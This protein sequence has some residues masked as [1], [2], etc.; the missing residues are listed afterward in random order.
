MHKTMVL[1]CLTLL[2]AGCSY[3]SVKHLASNPLRL[4]KQEEL[5]MRYWNFLYVN[6]K[7]NHHYLLR[8]IAFP[9][10]ENLPEWGSWIHNLSIAAYLSDELGVVLARDI[11]AH[12]TQRLDPE[13][14]IPV[15]FRLEPK[16]MPESRDVFVTFGY[17]MQLTED[18]CQDPDK[19]HTP[20][21]D[22]RVFFASEGALLR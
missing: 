22:T 11:K 16:R 9:R 17:R 10:Q 8:G 14:G 3:L 5:N 15:E 7:E 4:D 18:S 1:F 20:A 21:G 12:P 2:L 19:K 6:E 13:N